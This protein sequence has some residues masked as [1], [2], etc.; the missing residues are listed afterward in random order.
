MCIRGEKVTKLLRENVEDIYPLSSLQEGMLFHQE[1]EREKRLYVVQVIAEITGVLQ[2]GTFNKSIQHVLQTNEILRTV[3]RWKSTGDPLQIVLKEVNVELT[4]YDLADLERDI[5]EDGINSILAAEKAAIQIESCPIRFSIIKIGDSHNRIVITYHH[6]ICDGWSS[7]ILLKELFEAYDALA[8]GRIPMSHH[9]TKYKEYISWLKQQDVE[10]LSVFWENYLRGIGLSLKL[11]G[12]RKQMPITSPASCRYTIPGEI[13]NEIKHFLKVRNLT[14][15]I[16][17]YSAWGTLLQAQYNSKDAV[18]GIT[19]SGRH[20]EINGIDE[21][22]GLFIHTLPFRAVTAAKDVQGLLIETRNRFN[23]LCEYQTIPLAKVKASAK[24]RGGGEL[25]DT[26]VVV[27]NYPISEALS[28]PFHGIKIEHVEVKETT[29]YDIVLEA[30]AFEGLE[31]KIN[32]YEANFEAAYVEKLL[33]QLYSI[34]LIMVQGPYEPVDKLTGLFG[35][36]TTIDKEAAAFNVRDVPIIADDITTESEIE[37]RVAEIWRKVL[38]VDHIQSYDENFFHAGG[39][40]VKVMKVF[41]QIEK[42][43]PG[44]V[45]LVDLFTYPTIQRIAQ[46]IKTRNESI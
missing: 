44:V 36:K 15:P 21:M 29:H 30:I 35:N 33:E 7:A 20:P 23:E 5:C 16:L 17:L 27:E 10:R 40:S 38:K 22:V 12:K 43:Y 6:I 45:K 3:F 9:K 4:E 25:F 13:F 19:V 39:D 24:L 28:G 26:L 32:Y 18:F 42:E 46:F 2:R 14:L 41:N 31:L 34:I 11:P 37:V 8:G 1:L